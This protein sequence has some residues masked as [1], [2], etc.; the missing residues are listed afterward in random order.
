[1]TVYKK[2][3]SHVLWGP[4]NSHELNYECTNYYLY[5]QLQGCIHLPEKDKQTDVMIIK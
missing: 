5:I 1:M 4:G 3:H 2:C